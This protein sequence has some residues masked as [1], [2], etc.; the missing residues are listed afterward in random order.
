MICLP[1]NLNSEEL[2]NTIRE[3]CWDAAK[4]FRSYN[5]TIKNSKKLN[6]KNFETGPVTAADIEINQLIKNSIK[7]RCLKSIKQ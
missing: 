5:Q 1:D 6:V 7:N 2:L 4:I 3:L